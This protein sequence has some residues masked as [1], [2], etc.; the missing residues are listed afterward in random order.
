MTNE[1]EGGVRRYPQ[2]G[3]TG[4]RIGVAHDAI[5]KDMPVSKNGIESHP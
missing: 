1:V 2:S 4:L 5:A 3:L